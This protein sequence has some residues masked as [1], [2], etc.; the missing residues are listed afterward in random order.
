MSEENMFAE[1]AAKMGVTLDEPEAP[2]KDVA[3]PQQEVPQEAVEEPEETG[4]ELS[5]EDIARSNGWNEN[6]EFTAAEFNR[7][8]ELFGKISEQKKE[9]KNLT[10]R[11]E[12]Q[13]QAFQELQ[14]Y[15]KAQEDAK[16]QA[17][18]NELEQ[19][20]LEAVETGDVQAYQQLDQEQKFME[21]PGAQAP[22]AESP[23]IQAF[24]ERNKG[25]YN[26]DTIENY[27]MAQF[28]NQV[29]QFVSVT[30]PN[31]DEATRLKTVEVEV[32][33]RYPARFTNPSKAAP[34]PVAAAA[35]AEQ[36]SSPKK[37]TVDI[38]QLDSRQKALYNMAQRGDVPG[39][40][41][42]EY[43]KG[44]EQAYNKR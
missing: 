20:K 19:Q 28:A 44:L 1:E 11:V 36:K 24:A 26:T 4:V 12:E 18:L 13:I 37:G 7:R 21:Q 39:M 14:V 29:S 17:R 2:V 35:K 10:S 25:W 15:N 43:L 30:Q 8:G 23:E 42:E 33:K 22:Q 27:E 41:G 5:D 40:T 32:R 9:I 34:A 31:M 3:E 6:G 16:V 38:S